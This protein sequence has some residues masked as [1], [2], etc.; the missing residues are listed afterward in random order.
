[1]INLNSTSSSPTLLE[2]EQ[3]VQNPI[4][5]QFCS[6]IK[7]TYSCNEKIEFSSCSW[8][9]GWNVK[10]KKAGKTLCTIY[11]KE[12]FITVMVVIGRKEK[13]FVEAILPELTAELQ[14]VYKQTNE[15]NGQRWLMLDLREQGDLY[16]DILRLIEIR[17]NC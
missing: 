15:G 10:F 11:P 14:A 13:E 1:M 12:N 5:G 2:I 3:Y 7:Q 16:K 4:F 17:R 8:A 6:E 9:F